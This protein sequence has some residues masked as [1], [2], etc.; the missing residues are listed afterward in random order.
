MLTKTLCPHCGNS[1]LAEPKDGG[2]TTCPQCRSFVPTDGA[3]HQP[4]SAPP[5]VHQTPPPEVYAVPASVDPHAPRFDPTTPPPSYVRGERLVRGLIF[6]AVAAVAFGT[7]FGA[8]T[9]AIRL[10]LPLLG[11]IVTGIVTGI[12]VR[13]GFGGRS[14]P[15]TRGRAS[16]AAAFCAALG[17]TASLGGAWMVERWTGDRAPTTQRD[18]SSGLKN[19]QARRAQTVDASDRA[20]LDHRIREVHRLQALTDAQIEDYLRVQQAGIAQPLMAYAWDRVKNGP[21]VRLGPE[22]RTVY[23]GGDYGT[24]AG[25]GLDFLLVMWLATRGVRPLLVRERRR[26]YEA[27]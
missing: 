27:F 26:H 9:A 13:H 6:G 15:S 19:L 2:G 4:T 8:G 21:L 25:W 18:L 11:G 14:V 10:T 22:G 16:S 7:F 12:V 20:T 5:E 1:F 24:A 17:L 3:V 23:L